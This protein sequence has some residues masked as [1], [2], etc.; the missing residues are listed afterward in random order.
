MKNLLAVFLGGGLGSLLRHALSLAV[1]AHAFPAATLAVNAAGC[2]LIGCFGALAVRF[3]WSE[4][5]S[6]ALATGLC[7]GFTTFSTFSKE[8]LALLQGGRPAAFALYVA[9]SVLLGLA[10]AALG[11][12]AAK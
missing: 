4:T 6:L 10:A 1:G 8:A 2:F 12:A 11:F 3:S 9:A 5:T 7:G